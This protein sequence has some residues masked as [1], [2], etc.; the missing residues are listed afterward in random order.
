MFPFKIS[1][2]PLGSA[3]K[4]GKWDGMESNYRLFKKW[5]S[6]HAEREGNA[7]A[8]QVNL[9]R[10]EGPT[11][12]SGRVLPGAEGPGGRETGKPILMEC[13][14]SKRSLHLK[15][16]REM[17]NRILIIGVLVLMGCTTQSHVSVM[18]KYATEAERICAR[19]C[20]GIY[21]Q[22]NNSCSRMSGDFAPTADRQ[23][24]RCL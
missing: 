4:W 14:H 13:K 5:I 21:A 22:C 16:G 7:Q 1:M 15:G 10:V 23:R 20:Q 12:K 3:G 17:K 8:I 11:P 2:I 9:A 24:K 18:P 6:N 19:N